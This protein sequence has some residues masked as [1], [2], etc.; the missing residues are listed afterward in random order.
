MVRPRFFNDPELVLQNLI[1]SKTIDPTPLL[2]HSPESIHVN[3]YIARPLKVR[4]V[5]Y[6]KE[7][8]LDVSI[9]ACMALQTQSIPQNIG[10]S[11]KV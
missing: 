7:H 9:R 8:C 6:E 3:V 5:G 11:Y 10:A 4:S 2:N 1:V